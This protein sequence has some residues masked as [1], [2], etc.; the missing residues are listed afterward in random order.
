[1]TDKTEGLDFQRYAIERADHK[2][3]DHAIVLEF[4]DPN[5]WP[6]LRVWADT[7]E[8]DGYHELAN[9]VRQTLRLY[10]DKK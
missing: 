7:V 4:N 2:P 10:Q 8:K 6:A 5:S 1:M 9:D 3:V